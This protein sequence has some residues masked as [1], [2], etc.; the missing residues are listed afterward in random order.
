MSEKPNFKVTHTHIGMFADNR[1][2]ISFTTRCQCGKEF[3]ISEDNNF[4][5]K[6]G[7]KLPKF[8]GIKSN[9]IYFDE[10][11]NI[12]NLTAFMNDWLEEHMVET[13]K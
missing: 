8:E 13:T 1:P 5:G 4:C 11:Y 3:P 9:Q 10:L 7:R 2:F 6:C 12:K